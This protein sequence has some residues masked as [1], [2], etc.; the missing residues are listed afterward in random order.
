V[1]NASILSR[2]IEP[3]THAPV[4]ALIGLGAV[5]VGFL[6]ARAFYRNAKE[7]PLPARLGGLSRAMQNRFYF[8]EIYEA[9]FI[10]AH[11]AIAAI[12]AFVD[13]W[14][15]DGFCIGLIR[16]GTSLLGYSLRM[17]QSGNLQFYAFVFV[18]GVALVLYFVLGK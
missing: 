14:I 18:F 10:R 7:D 8:D 15:V 4:G 11:D 9:T 1:E 13:R 3:F 2:L 12:A 16:G 17:V 5:L 6:A